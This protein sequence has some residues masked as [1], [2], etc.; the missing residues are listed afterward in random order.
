MKNLAPGKS[1]AKLLEPPPPS[2]TRIPPPTLPYGDFPDMELIG[3]GTM[4]DQGFPYIAPYCAQ[5]PHPFV[6]HDVN[7]SDWRHFLHDIRI[8]GSLSPTNRIVSGVLPMAFGVGFIISLFA[9][10][11]VE[12]YMRRRKKGPVSQLIDHWNALFFHPRLMHIAL[13]KGPKDRHAKRGP[14]QATDKNWRLVIS[15]RPHRA[16]AS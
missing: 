12:G 10:F 5:M 6:M 7:E 3:K 1:P 4:L 9:T 15:Y 16:H 8:A 14:P 13:A 11:G 2:F